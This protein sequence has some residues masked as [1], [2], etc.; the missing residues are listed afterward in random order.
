MFDDRSESAKGHAVLTTRYINGSRRHD[1]F[2]PD[3]EAFWAFSW[4]EMAKYDLPAMI[5]H[6]TN[7][8]KQPKIFYVG[9]SQGNR[10]L[11]RTGSVTDVWGPCN[12][13]RMGAP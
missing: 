12:N 4:D 13:Y 7:V 6:V 3:S 2:S 5:E 11:A 10:H 1:K 9:H 8:T